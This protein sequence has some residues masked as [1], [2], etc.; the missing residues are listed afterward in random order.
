M[1]HYNL[2]PIIDILKKVERRVRITR[3][4]LRDISQTFSIRAETALGNSKESLGDVTKAESELKI[5][6]GYIEHF[7]GTLEKEMEAEAAARKADRGG[8]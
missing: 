7:A 8:V 2:A 6:R 4:T 1:P 3:E 5:A